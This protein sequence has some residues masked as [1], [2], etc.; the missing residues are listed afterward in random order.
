MAEKHFSEQR[1]HAETYL[2]PF[3]ERNCPN[4][5]RFQ[6][7]DVGCAEAGFLDA[8][9]AAG[10]MGMGLEVEPARIAL[11]KRF[12]PDLDI[13]EGDITDPGIISRINKKFDLIVMRDV[14]EHIPDKDTALE[15]LNALLRPD[16][17]LYI[18]FPPRLSPFGG[19][20]QNGRSLL[21]KVPYLHLLPSSVIR[22]LGKAFGEY[23]DTVE[24][25]I[26]QCQIGL[27]IG[28]FEEL[29][30]R[31]RYQIHC[32]E[33]FLFRPVFRVR[34]GLPTQRMPDIPG[35]REFLVLGC[36]CLLQKAP[37]R[38]AR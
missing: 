28:Q 38:S 3:L 9:H 34:Y 29:I 8:L 24:S 27:T 32:K 5:H 4:F 14:I 23:P 15:H 11:S 36:E 2:I 25:V 7:L 26:T 33:F 17:F 6:I 13:L 1:K 12:N 22:A 37:A 19:H 16:G 35:V 10:V 31:H 30:V 21:S 20:Q 18:T